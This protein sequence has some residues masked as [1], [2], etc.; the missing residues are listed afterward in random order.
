LGVVNTLSEED[1]VEIL[2]GW[3]KIS[4]EEGVVCGGLG[5]SADEVASFEES[6]EE[7]EEGGGGGREEEEDDDDDLSTLEILELLTD[8]EEE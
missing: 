6:I 8:E 1:D 5:A 7:E 4:E 2:S 3:V